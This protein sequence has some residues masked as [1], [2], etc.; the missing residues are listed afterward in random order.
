MDIR[1][2]I[3]ALSALEKAIYFCWVPSHCGIAGNEKA[4]ELAKRASLDEVNLISLPHS[5]YHQSFKQEV[6][7]SYGRLKKAT[8]YLL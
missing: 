8:N 5:D 7:K 3:I 1:A 4:D 2:R 6:D